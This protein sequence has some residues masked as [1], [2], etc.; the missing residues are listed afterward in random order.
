MHKLTS[1]NTFQNN[2]VKQTVS[3]YIALG[4]SVS[5]YVFF[6]QKP[7]HFHPKKFFFQQEAVLKLSCLLY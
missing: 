4:I 6:C 7:K 1:E 5:N 2:F 3:K